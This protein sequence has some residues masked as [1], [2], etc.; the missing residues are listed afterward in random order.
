MRFCVCMFECISSSMYLLKYFGVFSQALWHCTVYHSD[1]YF[2]LQFRCSM[3]FFFSLFFF[4]HWLFSTSLH[5]H[6]RTHMY[7]CIDSSYCPL[8][9]NGSTTILHLHFISLYTKW[10]KKNTQIIDSN[11]PFNYW[12]H[13]MWWVSMC[14]WK[15]ET[16]A[17]TT[18][19]RM[20]TN[21][22]WFHYWH[23][24]FKLKEQKENLPMKWT[25]IS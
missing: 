12:T 11:V 8:N 19:M 9:F 22:N 2:F 20:Q 6:T 18:P 23:R 1:F 21:D 7:V 4:I 24:H 25:F 14:I 3:L 17:T 5:R 10:M 13:K 15:R 16:S